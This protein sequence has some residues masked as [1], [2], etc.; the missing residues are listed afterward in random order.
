MEE[1][2]DEDYDLLNILCGNIIFY[3]DIFNW[4]KN[5]NYNLKI[6]KDSYIIN[7]NNNNC[8]NSTELTDIIFKSTTSSLIQQLTNNIK[9]KVII[10]DN[11]DCIYMADK[12]INA[13][14]L[15]IL[16]EKKIKNIPIICIANEEIIKKIGDIK[17]LCK[18]YKLEIPSKNE[19][20]NYL[21]NIK[22]E[23]IKLSKNYIT[24]SKIQ[25]IYSF[26]Y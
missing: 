3:K 18:I 17:K 24:R 6:S 9:K 19:I 22:Y 7:I 2:I 1:I 23:N 25:F 11:F 26:F 16:I 8:F 4:L 13:T 20:C 14:L 12:T 5:F 15:K 10:I 21:S